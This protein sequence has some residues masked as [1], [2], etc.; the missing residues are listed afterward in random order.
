MELK[1]RSI[2]EPPSIQNSRFEHM[3]LYKT[4][5]LTKVHPVDRYDTRLNARDTFR[6]LPI[7]A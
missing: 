5:I 4:C 7:L 1:A 6:I 2:P 3:K